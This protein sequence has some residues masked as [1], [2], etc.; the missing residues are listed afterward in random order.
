MKDKCHKEGEMEKVGFHFFAVYSLL[1]KCLEAQ[2]NV[3][4][5]SKC[6]DGQNSGGCVKSMEEN[7]I[8]C[9]KILSR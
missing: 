2:R 3:Y 7:G 8:N 1:H 5:D 4:R 9:S 6:A